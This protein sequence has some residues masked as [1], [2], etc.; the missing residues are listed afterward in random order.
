VWDTAT[1]RP[2]LTLRG[3]A[4]GVRGVCFSPDGKLLA[5]AGADRTVK[6]WEVARGR[7]LLTLTGHTNTVW[8]VCFSRDGRRVAAGAVGGAIKVWDT[9][10]GQEILTLKGHAIQVYAVAFSADG[11]RLV[12]A[13]QD[14]TVKVWD[15]VSGQELL[16]FKGFFGYVE[17][18]CFSPDG[19]RLAAASWD[20]TV[21]V[22][23]TADGQEVFTL[24]GHSQPVTGVC[25]SQDGRRLVSQDRNGA[26]RCWS[27]T[28]G[29]EIVP[30]T[31]APPPEGQ[32]E[33]VSPD[34]ALRV[35]ADGV[36]VRVV[37]ADDQRPPSELV[38]LRRL[39]DP[40]ARRRWHHAEADAAWAAG[41][42]LAAAHHLGQLL[43]RADP[44]DDPSAL[45]VRCLR[46]RTLQ[47]AADAGPLR[48]A[49]SRPPAQATDEERTLAGLYL[50]L[51][52]P[53]HRVPSWCGADRHAALLA[54]LRDAEERLLR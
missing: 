11:T 28:S 50:L 36:T 49:A 2:L 20:G 46:A 27:T 25:F 29:Q 3:H 53:P 9:A 18:V 12:S 33:A 32:R 16:T 35:R 13:S 7:E 4:G 52:V 45:A 43:R 1:G 48:A 19:R 8:C 23:Q 31:D 47:H 14:K 44:A 10:G 54:A 34:G 21:R 42:W 37:R 5:T 24:T 39:T 6:L 30:C 51:D 17:S 38:F 22:R 40:S 26:V 15:A 41:H